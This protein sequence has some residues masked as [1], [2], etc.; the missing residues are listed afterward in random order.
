[1][2]CNVD[3]VILKLEYRVWDGEQYS[4][5][6]SHD[7]LEDGGN[8]HDDAGNTIYTLEEYESAVDYLIECAKEDNRVNGGDH[9]EACV[10]SDSR[11]YWWED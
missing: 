2:K 9:Y 1:M 4:P 6:A 3:G 10:L 8:A 5:D 7:I 11:G